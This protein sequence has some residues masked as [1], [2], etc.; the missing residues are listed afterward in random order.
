MLVLC[1]TNIIISP[2]NR[3]RSCNE[4]AAKDSL[5]VKQQL[6]TQSYTIEH[7]VQVI[8]IENVVKYYVY[9]E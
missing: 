1:N 9:G 5:G 3:T 6:L 7:N 8:F 2:S 4:I